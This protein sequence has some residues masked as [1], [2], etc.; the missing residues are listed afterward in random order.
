M[1]RRKRIQHPAAK[2]VFHAVHSGQLLREPCEKCGSIQM[3]EAHHEDYSK[4]LEVRWL[5]HVCH[6]ALHAERRPPNPAKCGH[7]LV[8]AL[9]L[10]RSCYEKDLRERNP[11]FAERQRENC[12]QWHGREENE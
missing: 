12:R 11:E 8:Y 10:C 7:G 6:M 2:V 1:G 9:N 4:A 3:V 5:C